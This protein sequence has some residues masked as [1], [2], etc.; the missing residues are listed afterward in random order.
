MFLD[1]ILV[2]SSTWEDD[3]LNLR[4]TLEVLKQQQLYA[5]LSKCSFGQESV[6][7]LRHVITSRQVAME[8]DKVKSVEKCLYLG[9]LGP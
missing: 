4:L 3:L 8:K 5:K 6:T 9:I 7:N 1:D 2:C